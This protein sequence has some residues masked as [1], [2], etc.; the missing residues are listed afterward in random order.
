MLFILLQTSALSEVINDIRINGNSR[1]S[2]ETIK[3]YG[4][5]KLK[6]DYDQKKLNQIL[7]NLFETNF[8]EDVNLKIFKIF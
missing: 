6:E 2:D 7:R 1:I 3:I 4:E 5:I 8:F